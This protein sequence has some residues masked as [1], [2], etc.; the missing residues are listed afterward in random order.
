MVVKISPATVWS[1]RDGGGLGWGGVFR[2][3]SVAAF[4]FVEFVGIPASV[5]KNGAA[6]KCNEMK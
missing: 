5:C 2:H 1:R 3:L 4:V 6:L